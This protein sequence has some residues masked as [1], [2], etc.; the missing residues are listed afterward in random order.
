MIRLDHHRH[1]ARVQHLLDGI[2]DLRCQLLLNLKPLGIGIHHAG[3]L[4]NAD[5]APARQIRHMRPPHDR[6]HM[7]LAM[8]LQ[9]DILQQH[10]LVI[11]I[12]LLEGAGEDRHRVFAVTLEEFL[13]RFH[14][15]PGC[16]HQPLAGWV[17]AG[18]KQ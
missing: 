3:Q 13:V 17:L 16:V 9:P 2:G 11:A 5:D 6:H 1:P 4:G 18:P 7:V 14:H 8:A 10:D 12:R 15:A